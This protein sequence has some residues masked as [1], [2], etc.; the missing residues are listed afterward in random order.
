[1]RNHQ[2]SDSLADVLERMKCFFSPK[3]GIANRLYIEEMKQKRITRKDFGTLAF[4]NV[5]PMYVSTVL[6]S[7]QPS[8][9]GAGASLSKEKSQIKAFGEFIERFSAT[10]IR[11]DHV[12]PLIY[13]TYENQCKL[14]NCLDLCELIDFDDSIYERKN[15]PYLRYTH[16]DII[17]WVKGME[18]T[19][20]TPAWIPAQKAYL[21]I[22]F[23]NGEMP[24]VQAISTG[25]ACGSSYEGAAVGGVLEVVE[26][27]SF[28]LTWLLKLHGKRIIIDAAQ[29]TELMDL[30]LHIT[31]HLVGDDRLFVYDISRTEG[32]YTVLTFIRNDNPNSYGLVTA[33]ASDIDPERA[34]LKSLEELCLSQAFAYEKLFESKESTHLL[35]NMRREDV[36]D[37]HAHFFYYGTGKNSCEFDFIDNPDLCIRLSE[38]QDYQSAAATDE[39]RLLYL[40]NL[41]KS[42][43]L[44]VY[45]VDLTRPEVAEC[46]LS[47]Y[48]MIIPGFNDLDIF[49]E[50]RMLSNRRLLAYQAQ[51]NAT[52][53]EAPHP[54]P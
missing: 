49:H 9:G 22:P 26:R 48:K 37:L 45:S 20:G 4:A 41:F 16:D 30:Y 46:G 11:D 1:M 2:V 14:G 32:V 34:L 40:I 17:S 33:A 42:Q 8:R 19:S 43:E 15:V 50:F 18:L 7:N 23:K 10:N 29:N 27:D 21:G 54:F 36:T 52:I 31:T 6:N 28:M 51:Y 44:P 3:Y 35:R 38:M 53:N 12:V 24:Y 5:I 47:V 13:N 25:L 39:E